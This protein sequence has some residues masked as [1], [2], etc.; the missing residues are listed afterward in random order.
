ML[1]LLIYG[2]AT[3]TTSGHKMERATYASL[4]FRYIACNQHPDHDTLAS[5]RK[6]SGKQFET[7]FVQLRQVAREKPLVR[8]GTV[9][10]DGSKIHPNSSRHSALSYT[11]AEKIEV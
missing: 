3:A 7:A 8:F 10:L 1:S 9:S 6:R 5:F 4:V 11:H 2:S